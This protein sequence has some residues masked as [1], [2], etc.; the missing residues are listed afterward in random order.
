VSASR[1][2]DARTLGWIAA[3]IAI[4]TAVVAVVIAAACAGEMRSWLEFRFGGVPR[5]PGAA[6][7]IFLNNMKLVVAAAIASAVAQM[8]LRAAAGQSTPIDAPMLRWV[9]R[10]CELGLGLATL[11]NV[12]IVGVAVGAYGR[13]MLVALLPHGPFELTAFCV[14]IS[15]YFTARRRPL[16][17]RDWLTALGS[18]A[19]LLA[20][21]ALLETFAWLG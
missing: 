21:A 19:A 16:S 10:L 1:P 12:A 2:F 17:V 20:A 18:S 11:A 9:A 6:V 14:A 4:L 13:R 15:L 3:A 7:S 8:K 5:T